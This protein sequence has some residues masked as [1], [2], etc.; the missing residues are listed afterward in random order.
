MQTIRTIRDCMPSTVSI[1]PR[2]AMA[3]L[4]SLRDKPLLDA[5]TIS[6]I[7]S[8]RHFLGAA[9]GRLLLTDYAKHAEIVHLGELVSDQFQT[10]GL[11]QY[12]AV[13]LGLILS[14][15]VI[16][17]E[18][19]K[20]VRRLLPGDFIG[21]FET[22]HYLNS[23]SNRK[24]GNWSLIADQPT[25]IMYFSDPATFRD[26]EDQIFDRFKSYLIDLARLDLVPKPITDLPL[27]DLIANRVTRSLLEDTLVVAHTHILPSS[28]P[29]FRH[30]AHLVGY[31]NMIV[32]EKS[33]STIRPISHKLIQMG[34]QVVPVI[35]IEGA[36]YEFAVKRSLDMVWEKVIN[37]QKRRKI[38][39]LLILDDG[40]DLLLTIPWEKLGTIEVL[41]VEQT[42]RG[43]VRLEGSANHCRLS[44]M[45][46]PVQS[47]KILNRSSSAKPLSIK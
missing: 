24:I 6:N 26:R 33:Y 25:S 38:R 31:Q 43:I 27:L 4:S 19:G 36:P 45:S 32:L 22:S 3:L 21:L 13:P 35:V 41:G 8:V 47:R 15:E 18:D 12:A 1:L 9:N 34:A 5:Q 23:H 2:Q 46:P 44:L 42:Q 10:Q 30:L 37:A 28:F 16:V 17:L 7:Q 29:L 14:G 20:G 11:K 39:R 40:A